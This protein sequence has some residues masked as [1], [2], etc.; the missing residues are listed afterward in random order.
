MQTDQ[1]SFGKLIIDTSDTILSALKKMDEVQAKL[2]IVFSQG[3]FYSLLSIGDIQRAIIKNIPLETEVI[4]ILRS[5]IEVADIDDDPEK[6]RSRMFK[7]RTELMPILD[8]DGNLADVYF[9]ENIF[10]E[11]N[12]IQNKQLNLPV[13]IMAGG[14]GTRLKPLTNVLPKPLIPIGEK[15]ILEDIMD[16]FL[17][18]GCNEFLISLNYKAE[19]IKHYLETLQNRDYKISY[20]QEENPSGTAGSLHLIKDK[21]HSTFF[22]SNCDILIDQDYSEIYNY[23]KENHNSITLVAALK[24]M[25]IPYGILET[26]DNGKLTTITEKPE[27]TFKINSG[28]YIL[29]PELLREIPENRIFHITELIANI[30]KRKGKVGVFPVSEGS[31]K[32]I[33]TWEGYQKLLVNHGI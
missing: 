6:V 12:F 9:W 19:V 30:I 11:K 33:G 29:E 24:H 31:W 1:L 27:F 3:K 16:R 14:K 17:N 4:H 22:L 2:L 32:D 15:T 8:K 5:S 23:H 26:A 18:V 20:F 13:V 7:D 28:M 21:I 10:P 25:K